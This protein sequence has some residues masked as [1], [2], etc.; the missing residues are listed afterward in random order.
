MLT[1]KPK[2]V[3]TTITVSLDADVWHAYRVACLTRHTS[4]SQEITRFM[5]QELDAWAQTPGT[6]KET[7]WDEK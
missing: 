3:R 2:T 1:T 5:R 4:A 6:R 7:I